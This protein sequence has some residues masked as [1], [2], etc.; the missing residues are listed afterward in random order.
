MASQFAYRA[1]LASASFPFPGS[2]T[3]GQTVIIGGQDQ[4]FSRQLSARADQDRSVGIPQVFF[5]RNIMPVEQGYAAVRS[6]NSIGGGFSGVS[7]NE[8]I[9]PVLQTVGA[10]VSVNVIQRDTGSVGQYGGGVVIGTTGTISSY[11]LNGVTYYYRP[12]E[13]YLISGGTKFVQG[14]AG[15]TM[16]AIRDMSACAGYNIAISDQT[17]FYS[18]TTNILDFVPSSVTGAGSSSVQYAQGRL[19]ML[20]PGVSG[21][22]IVCDQNIVFARYTGNRNFPFAFQPVESSGVVLPA[23]STLDL[24]TAKAGV[25]DCFMPSDEKYLTAGDGIFLLRPT[26]CIPVFPELTDYFAYIGSGSGQLQFLA[27]GE[28]NLT[29]SG[30]FA[31]G[32]SRVPAQVVHASQRYV[33]FKYKIVSGLNRIACWAVYD[34]NQQ[35][36]G[37]IY[38]AQL[39]T[40]FFDVGQAIGLEP[41]LVTAT[42]G[43]RRLEKYT[44]STAFQGS[45]SSYSSAIVMGRYQAQRAR[46]LELHSVD[47]QGGP[48]LLR[49]ACSVDGSNIATIHAPTAVQSQGSQV[50]Y[51]FNC[52]AAYNISLIGEGAF[53]LTSAVL[54]FSMHGKAML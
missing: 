5:G 3:H 21:I 19:R 31:G 17:F 35:R 6:G 14:I 47:M 9:L 28:Y 26:G 40:D 49:A 34:T 50:R 43:I 38:G 11:I 16:S 13:N 24:I 48:A 23:S 36:W 41:N 42:V 1:N 10:A 29:N 39:I 8:E 22:Y 20:L 54:N 4:N 46:M 30:N 7:A 32:G 15:L 25:S 44:P 53:H 18:S 51:Y 37:Q 33:C 2:A 27:P 45:A 52:P 12:T